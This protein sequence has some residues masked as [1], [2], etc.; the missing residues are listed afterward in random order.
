MGSERSSRNPEE[1]IRPLNLSTDLNKVADLV[2]TCFHIQHD[3]DGQTYIRE[4]RRSAREYRHLGW[5]PQIDDL[6]NKQPAGYVWVENEQIIGNLSMIPFKSG[7]KKFLL[8]ANVA[9]HSEHRRKGIARALTIRTLEHLKKHDKGEVWLQVRLDNQPAVDL[10][11]SVG[12]V[13]QYTRTT[14]R[15]LPNQ[16]IGWKD[17]D[18]CQIALKPSHERDW[19]KQ[20][21]YLAQTYPKNMRW[22]LP[23][24]FQRFHPGVLQGITNFLDGVSLRRWG[25]EDHGNACG[26]IT[27]QKTDTYANNIWLA[28]REDMEPSLLPDAL[29]QVILRLNKRHAVSVDYP[30]GRFKE[31]FERLGFGCFRTLI[32][33]RLV[34]N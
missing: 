6:R 29:T 34:L 16:I 14:W 10:Y 19:G 33:M 22:N 20:Q 12:F 11:R 15:I 13:D 7:D 27:W 26:W 5:L 9:V 25:I 21:L 2:E 8:L 30:F 17:R 18:T 24:N 32:W 4:M 1:H 28:F 31:G 23:I 3:P